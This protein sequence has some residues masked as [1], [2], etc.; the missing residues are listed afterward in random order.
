VRYGDRDYRVIAK[1]TPG[2]QPFPRV[3]SDSPRYLDPGAQPRVR[4]V[5]ILHDAEDVTDDLIP[6]TV[7]A[8]RETVEHR[9]RQAVKA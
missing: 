1:I 2:R 8:I 6:E 4:L 5:R 7:Q 3:A 9:V